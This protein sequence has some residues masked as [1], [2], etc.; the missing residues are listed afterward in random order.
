MKTDPDNPPPADVINS[1]KE[2]YDYLIHTVI[3]K[4]HVQF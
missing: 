4:L 3:Q 2:K 1:T